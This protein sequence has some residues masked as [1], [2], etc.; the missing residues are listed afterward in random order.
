MLTNAFY[1]WPM[2]LLKL[3]VV[4]VEIIVPDAIVKEWAYHVLNIALTM[5]GVMRSDVMS[6][7][8]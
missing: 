6:D 7:R 2:N 3:V 8:H 4:K 1:L 5:E